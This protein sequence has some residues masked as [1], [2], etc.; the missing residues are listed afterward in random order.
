MSVKIHI[1]KTH[2]QYTDGL[3]VVETTGETVGMCLA[4]LVNQFPS[5]KPEILT[6]DGT[7]T[8]KIEIYLNMESAYPDELGKPVKDGDDIHLTL[9]LAG[10]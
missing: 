4:D 6:D 7:P 5:I 2:R 8:R 10:G 1:H 3:S 9:L